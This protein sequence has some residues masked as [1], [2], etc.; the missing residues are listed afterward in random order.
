MF[1]LVCVISFLVSCGRA[2]NAKE[3]NETITD[4]HGGVPPIPDATTAWEHVQACALTWLGLDYNGDAQQHR[5]TPDN[6][7]VPCK[8]RFAAI[9][10][11]KAEVCVDTPAK[12]A[13]LNIIYSTVAGAKLAEKKRVNRF[14]TRSAVANNVEG[15]WAV[16]VGKDEADPARV[17]LAAASAKGILK[18]RYD[19]SRNLGGDVTLAA[20]LAAGLKSLRVRNT[21][22]GAHD[23]PSTQW[24]EWELDIASNIGILDTLNE[25]GFKDPTTRR[26]ALCKALNDLHPGAAKQG[27][28]GSWVD[29]DHVSGHRR[30]NDTFTWDGTTVTDDVGTVAGGVSPGWYA[31]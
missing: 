17:S 30:G 19:W 12:K 21:A 6:P 18:T 13:D 3:L 2:A 5:T 16:E 25:I 20:T 15:C 11:A 27:H 29:L 24:K 4:A 14:N 28:G 8:A 10:Q 31:A 26:K 22:L 7:T 1:L 23:D 9:A